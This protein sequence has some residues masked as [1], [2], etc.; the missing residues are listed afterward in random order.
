MHVIPTLNRSYLDPG[1]Y[2]S[3]INKTKYGVQHTRKQPK[4]IHKVL[5]VLMLDGLGGT[6]KASEHVG[7]WTSS[8]ASNL[9]GVAIVAS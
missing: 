4:T 6:G 3:I 1:L 7:T 8:A 2:V 9:N 5:T